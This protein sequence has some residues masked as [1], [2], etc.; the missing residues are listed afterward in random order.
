MNPPDLNLITELV[1]PE[2]EKIEQE[3][4][5]PCYVYSPRGVSL[6]AED[7]WPIDYS[8][9]QL[10]G[11]P[12]QIFWKSM[13]QAH[14]RSA[15]SAGVQKVLRLSAEQ[16]IDRL[17][18]LPELEGYLVRRIQSSI[19]L[20]GDIDRELRGKICLKSIPIWE[21]TLGFDSVFRFLNKRIEFEKTLTPEIEHAGYWNRVCFICRNRPYIPWLI[22]LL[23]STTIGII[24]LAN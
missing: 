5:R 7:E 13:I 10:S 24:T 21:P 22:A 23:G 6:P 20:M 4:I 15:I 3:V 12:R 9:D 18:L 11:T 14:F 17:S 1:D 2:F 8:G 16:K 19:D